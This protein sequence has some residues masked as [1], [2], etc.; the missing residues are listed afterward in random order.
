MRE[1]LAY[2]FLGLRRF[3]VAHHHDRFEIGTIP[4]A[5]EAAQRIVP[6]GLEDIFFADRQARGVERAVEYFGQQLAPHAFVRATAQ[7]QFLQYHRRFGDDRVVLQRGALRPILQHAET[8][9]EVFFLAGGNG[10]DVYRLVETGIGVQVGT[11]L[12]ADRLQ[13]GNQLMLLEVLRSVELHVFGEMCQALLVVVFQDRAGLDDEAQFDVFLRLAI[14][15]NVVMQAIRQYAL[16]QRR[17]ER[18]GVRKIARALRAP[19]ENQEGSSNESL[20]QPGSRHRKARKNGEWTWGA[21]IRQA[22]TSRIKGG[23]HHTVIAFLDCASSKKFQAGK[24][25]ERRRQSK[26]CTGHMALIAGTLQLQRNS[27]T[28]KPC[29]LNKTNCQM[30]AASATR[31][32]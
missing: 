9:F 4:V 19:G 17:I 18:N 30:N 28:I 21:P 5:V 11:E 26:R 29:G 25:S 27:A 12:D 20:A 15:E 31:Q 24:A 2:H 7:A 14:L 10:Q 1:M 32:T 23:F 16:L 22:A 13:I 3:D 6:E 8:G